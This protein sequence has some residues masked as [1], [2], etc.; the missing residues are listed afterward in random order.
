MKRLVAMILSLVLFVSFL[1]LSVSA[2]TEIKQAT[3]DNNVLTATVHCE[4]GSSALDCPETRITSPI[5]TTRTTTRVP[6][7]SAVIS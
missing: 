5:I 3:L 4:T 6:S 2:V 7:R 1:P